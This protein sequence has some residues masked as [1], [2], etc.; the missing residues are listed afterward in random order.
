MQPDKSPIREFTHQNLKLQ[1][2][3]KERDIHT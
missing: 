1:D 2:E 3:V